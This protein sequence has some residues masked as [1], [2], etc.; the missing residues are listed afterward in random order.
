MR[1]RVCAILLFVLCGGVMAT[2]QNITGTIVGTVQDQSGAPVLSA[3]ITALNTDT[4]IPY[5]AATNETGAYVLPLLPPGSYQVIIE[6]SG[7]KKFLRDGLRLGADQRLRVDA[8]LEIGAVSEQVTVSGAA[9][10]IKTDQAALGDSFVPEDFIDLPISGNVTN[11][12][13][14][15]PGIA[16]NA[17]GLLNA[18]VNGSRDT[19]SDFK[20]DGATT[21]N[22]NNGLGTIN[23]PMESV[24]EFVVQSGLYSAEFGRGV[25]QI[26]I[27]TRAGTNRLHGVVYPGHNNSALQANSYFNN[28]YGVP[29]P[30][31][32]SGSLGVT[33]SGPVRLPKLYD[34]RNRTFFT[35]TLTANR[36]A[37]PQQ[38]VSSVPTLAMRAGDFTGQPGIYDPATTRETPGV[39]AGFARD[40]FPLNRIPA[41]RMDPVALEMLAKSY[42]EPNL[43]GANNYVNA[44]SPTSSGANYQVR[45]DHNFN[46]KSRITARYLY[47]PSENVNL[48]R[49]PGPGGGAGNI[50]LNERFAP[51][52]L[53]FEHTYLFRPNLVNSLRY[54]Y[55]RIHNTRSGADSNQDWPAKLGL[56]NLP[57]A[58]FPV[59]NITGLSPFGGSVLSDIV[60]SN[61]QQVAD[62]LVWVRGR[63]SVK[64][65]GE[66]RLLDFWAW[67]P[68]GPNFTFDTSP[69][70]NAQSLR[71]GVG[72][73]SFLLGL[74]SNSIVNMVPREPLSY[75]IRYFAAYIQD[76][77]RVTNKLTL[78]LGIRWEMSTPRIEKN[79]R[80]SNFDLGT[81]QLRI[82]G[83]DGYPSTLFDY[84]WKDFQPRI[85]FAYAP[86][87][88]RRTVV[89]GGYGLFFTPSNASGTGSLT[90]LGPWQRSYTY[91][92]QNDITYPYSLQV[93]GPAHSF[94]EPYVLSPLTAVTRVSRDYPDAYMQQWS[95][96]VQREIVPGTL[97][98]AGYVGS[99]GTHLSFSYQLNQV[100]ADRLGP[101]NAQTRRPYPDRGNILASFSPVGNSFYHAGQLRFRRRLQGGLSLMGSYTYSKSIDDA[102]GI[103][104][105]FTVGYS[106]A[107]DNYNLR[108]ERSESSFSFRHNLGYSLLWQVPVGKGRYFLNRSGI[109][110][111]ILGG[112]SASLLSTVFSG[113]PLVMTT[114]TNT[115]GSLGGGSRP[116]RLRDGK[117]SGETRGLLRWFDATAFAL[118]DPYTFGND[119]RT[120]PGLCA[121]GSV[122]VNMMIFKDFR[123]GEGKTLQIRSEARNILNHFNPGIPNTIIGNAAVGT[124]TS[125][126]LPRAVGVSVRFVF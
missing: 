64:F 68:S 69:T 37:R 86:F 28:A 102:S 63:H 56:K 12:M 70:R 59:A 51:R 101:G 32:H 114:L 22:S 30:V 62:S 27:T 41:S 36:G 45:A 78:N 115:T 66:Y 107:Q 118:P 2:A 88:G 89:R 100:P 39:G 104:G 9:S 116:N 20:V 31:V 126:S 82:A 17:Q 23:V 54:G 60:P 110:N 40:P 26:N 15:V 80:Q 91:I 19:S 119:S 44:G 97:V 16:A 79:N 90:T 87:G 42:P 117:L 11:L 38:I 4:G 61:N 76:D 46:A 13:Q 84:A 106:T 85:G 75:R 99:K 14:L 49:Y 33:L 95:F 34:G 111:G 81:L 93:G 83:Q 29:R 121:P 124:I 92:T 3:E 52:T 65:G 6:V 57:P 24:E 94:D 108:A 72:F 73:A 1:T 120:E 58:I 98:E 53:A 43:A 123:I 10:F 105:A 35:F 96:N 21:T 103:G 55:Y 125:G 5:K 122:N 48:M 71:D 77:Y 47:Q 109:A 67:T 25:T 112:W 74:P 7:F 113:R 8:K 18:N 50:A